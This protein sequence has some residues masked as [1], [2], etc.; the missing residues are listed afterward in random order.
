MPTT[1]SNERIVT[2]VTRPERPK[3][4][5]DEVKRSPKGRKLE[6]G[7]RRA[8]KL[9]VV[10][11]PSL[12]KRLAVGGNGTFSVTRV[13]PSALIFNSSGNRAI[14]SF[15]AKPYIHRWKESCIYLHTPVL[16]YTCIYFCIYLHILV[17]Y[18]C[19]AGN[20]KM[21]IRSC[22]MSSCLRSRSTLAA[23]SLVAIRNIGWFASKYHLH[24]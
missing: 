10:N 18:T 23:R 5:K 2:W 22:T 9:L 3:G 24:M 16:V 4:A 14:S 12:Y 19:P 20:T 13:Y 6:V 7:A 21:S 17:V 1:L 8:P 15:A 11:K